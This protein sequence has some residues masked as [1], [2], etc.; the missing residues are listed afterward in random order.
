MHNVNLKNK[1]LKKVAISD[2]FEIL[3]ILEC[4]RVQWSIEEKKLILQC[5]LGEYKKRIVYRNNDN[6]YTYNPD[7]NI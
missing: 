5:D 3:K 2:N 4:F 6:Y 7:I 1:I